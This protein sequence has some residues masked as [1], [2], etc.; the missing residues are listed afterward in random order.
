MGDEMTEPAEMPATTPAD[1]SASATQLSILLSS[2]TSAIDE[3][4]KRS[5]RLDTKSRN[6]IT[7]VGSFFAV[8]QAVVVGLFNGSLASTEHHAAS[9][10]VPWLAV[11]GAAASIA[12]LIAAYVSYASWK[13]L[14]DKTLGIGTIRAY[15]DAARK[16]NPVVG[17]NLVMAYSEIAEGRRENNAKRAKALERASGFCGVAMLFIGI[18]LVLAFIAAAVQ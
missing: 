18:E 12:T 14:D 9:S 1:G 8:V 15:V 4:F 5:E 10:F 17:V 7:I 11:A 2:A 6:Q 16:G 3:E 13:L